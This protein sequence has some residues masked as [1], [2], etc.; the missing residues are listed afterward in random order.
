MSRPLQNLHDLSTLHVNVSKA[1]SRFRSLE[2]FDDL[3]SRTEI[4]MLE[5]KPFETA[6]R[7]ARAEESRQ[8]KQCG[9]ESLDM[10]KEDTPSLHDLIAAADPADVLEFESRWA[11]LDAQSEAVLD[12]MN[13]GT[14]CVADSIGLTQRRVQQ[15]FKAHIDRV[16]A[17]HKFKK[18]G[19]GQ[20]GLFDGGE[21]SNGL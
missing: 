18:G 8:F 12:V 17:A 9:Y 2:Y 1:L 16:A 10:H 5:G 3:V 19:T 4:Y 13:K 21:V 11:M 14:R 20:G 6:W 15:I 7:N